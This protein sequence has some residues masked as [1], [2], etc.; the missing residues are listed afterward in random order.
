M[1]KFGIKKEEDKIYL[2]NI[3]GILHLKEGDIFFKTNTNKNYLD[4]L[5]HF[6]ESINKDYIIKVIELLQEDKEYDFTKLEKG[7]LLEEIRNEKLNK[8][9]II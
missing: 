7:T 4:I 5:Y 1:K 6:T 9:G 8:L 3:K 2:Y